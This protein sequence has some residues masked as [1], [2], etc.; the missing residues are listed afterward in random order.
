MFSLDDNRIA[1]TNE[2]GTVAV[3]DANSGV[4]L[5][6]VLLGGSG[7]G[8]ALAFSRR[9]YAFIST[10]EEVAY[11]WKVDTGA[12]LAT[13]TRQNADGTLAVMFSGKSE[14]CAISPVGKWIATPSDK[15][16]HIWDTKTG[17]LAAKYEVHT[18]SVYSVG[19]SPDSKRVL[20][21]SGD[22]TIQVHTLDC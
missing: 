18:E 3:R 6:R 2:S 4:L 21:C 19:F 7:I 12:L 10:R 13:P 17:L 14:T 1:T 8:G 11:V 22:R 9:S 16:L 15:N 20:S 5:W